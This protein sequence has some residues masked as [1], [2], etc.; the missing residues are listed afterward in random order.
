MGQYYKPSILGKNKR[1]VELFM[2]SWDYTCG[3]KLM[4]HSW[5]GNKFVGAFENLILQKPQI[6]VWAGDYADEDKGLK[7]NVYQRCK[8]KLKVSP[9]LQLVKAKYIV[10]HTT[11]QFVDKSKVPNKGGWQIHPLP[12]LTC[13]ENG[14]GGGDFRSTD[15]QNL[16]GSWARHLISIEPRKPKG[17]T[18][19]FFNLVHT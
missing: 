18:E 12:L 6:V 19:V 2:E 17:Y 4:E 5:L 1:T 16:V 9:P 14:R 8:D 15:P 10:N 3:A 13:E 11:K 7:T